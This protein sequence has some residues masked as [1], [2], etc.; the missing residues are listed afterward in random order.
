MGPKVEAAQAFALATGRRAVIGSLEQIEEILAGSAG[1]QV[2]AAI[3]DA[4][5]QNPDL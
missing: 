4:I 2:C 1:T 5:S 3:A